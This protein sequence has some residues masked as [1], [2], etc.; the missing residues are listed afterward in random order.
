MNK[1]KI[2]AK[3]TTLFLVFGIGILLFTQHIIFSSSNRSVKKFEF[4]GNKEVFGKLLHTI[5]V[6]SEVHNPEDPLATHVLIKLDEHQ[7]LIKTPHSM[8]QIMGMAYTR[9]RADT[10]EIAL[11]ELVCDVNGVME[12]HKIDIK[13]IEIEAKRIPAAVA[14]KD[15][16]ENLKSSLLDFDK[17][18]ALIAKHHI[19]EI[20]EAPPF[21]VVA[22][23]TIIN[24][25]HYQ[26]PKNLTQKRSL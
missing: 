14:L 2:F 18:E 22:N 5:I 26:K 1:M 20:E 3:T 8:C 16:L 17:R 4:N 12:T 7:D 19:K 21:L 10:I 11:Q 15:K 9:S 24:S 13:L 23:N 6:S 25:S